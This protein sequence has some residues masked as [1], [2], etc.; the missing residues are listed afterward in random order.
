MAFRSPHPDVDIPAQS[1]TDFVLGSPRARPESAALV[2]AS[3][4]QV[5]TYRELRQQVKRVASGLA[6]LGIG[7]ADVVALCLPNSPEFAVVFHA[8]A[9]L[10]ATLTT[11]N[12]ANTA[13][14]LA[15]QL[16]DSSAKLIVCTAALADKVRVAVEASDRAIEI[17]TT[18]ETPG[19]RSLHSIAS[20]GDLPA[21]T[22]NPDSDVVVL[23][24]SSGTTGLPKGVML[25]HRNVVAN[26]M[27]IDTVE[28]PDT[29]A[30]VGVLPFF[31][32]YGMVAIL[33]FGLMRGATVVTLPRFELE[34]FLRVLQDW[35]IALAHIVPPIAVALA[36]HPCVDRYNLGHVETLFSA[37]APLSPELAQAVQQR[38]KTPISDPVQGRR[39]RRGAQGLHRALRGAY[40]GRGRG[41]RS[42]ASGALQ[43]GAP[44]RIH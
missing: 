9:C 11:M 8:V 19:V 24:Y 43:A 15:H 7:K 27:Q 26:L 20:E 6:A 10:G 16:G 29:R 39:V 17:V 34:S 28:R 38:L 30:L 42:S 21:V 32:I 2:D 40:G 33:N 35:P 31:H 37:A 22:I 18:D 3:T 25:T 13:Q 12:P 1:L 23:P 41:F 44:R 5:L 36:K 4:G 14:E